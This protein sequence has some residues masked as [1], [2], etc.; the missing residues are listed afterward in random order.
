MLTRQGLLTPQPHKRPSSA[1]LQFGAD[2]PNQQWQAKH[3]PLAP[4]RRLPPERMAPVTAYNVTA[5]RWARG[6][7]LY[8]DG[9][10]VTQSRSLATADRQVCDFLSLM[11]DIEDPSGLR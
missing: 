5:K 8:I 2:M 4:G 1:G 6:W 7:E 10:G 11:L 3:H 9:V